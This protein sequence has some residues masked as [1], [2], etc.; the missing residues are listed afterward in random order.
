MVSRAIANGV[1]HLAITDHDCVAD[2]SEVESTSEIQLISGVEVSCQ[3]ENLEI[4]VVGLYVDHGYVELKALLASQQAARKE[5]M[6]LMADKLTGLG[7]PGLLEYLLELPAIA[8]TR[9]HVASF[10]VERGACKTRQKAFKQFIG[11]GAKAYVP[12]DWCEL[13]E[14][15]AVI[16]ASGGIAVLAHPGRYPLNKRRLTKL[17][18][19]F[20]ETGGDAIE[21]RY[22]NISANTMRQLEELA[23]ANDL[24][25][26]AGSDFHDPAAHWTDIGKFPPLRGEL[27]ARSVMNHKRWQN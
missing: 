14:A 1:T 18:E 9:S 26:S 21:V 22:P 25:L 13:P 6:Q 5:R 10:L 24:F 11:K 27:E 4:H 15:V 7:Y 8:Y 19:S 17:V 16:R 12:G 23:T 2:L 3:W 20:R